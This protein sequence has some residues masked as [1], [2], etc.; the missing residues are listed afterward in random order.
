M[1]MRRGLNLACA[2]QRKAGLTPLSLSRCKSLLPAALE[3]PVQKA[4][5]EVI[6]LGKW[7]QPCSRYLP[8]VQF[9]KGVRVNGLVQTTPKTFKVF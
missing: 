2:G 5:S 4:D 9:V 8:R 3:A 1:Q 6:G 7:A